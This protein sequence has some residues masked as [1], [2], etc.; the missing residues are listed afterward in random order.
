[1]TGK[2]QKNREDQGMRILEAARDLFAG[3]GFD[4]VTMAEIADRAGVARATVFNHFGSKHAL[5][6]AITESVLVFYEQML[7]SALA[8]TERSTPDLVRE[9]F[10][11][12]G[13]GIELARRF[14]RGAFREIAKLQ[15]GFDEGGPG[16]RS[17]EA[18][19]EQIAK[20]LARGQERGELSRDHSPG[21]LAYAMDSLSHGTIIH[22]LYDD[23]S[24]SLRERMRRS[25]EVLLGPVE[26]GR[27][28]P[29]ADD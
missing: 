22:W 17:R 5:V 3:R 2:R 8:D 12:M 9:L 26:I 6:E 27:P 7:D 23:A 13:A 19:L 29:G 16:Q 11:T 10:D 25:A 20:L 28:A 18:A 1:M 14:Y 15:L 24:D 21:D 4:E